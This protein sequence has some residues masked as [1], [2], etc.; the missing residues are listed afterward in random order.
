MDAFGI[1][2]DANETEEAR[3]AHLR[4]ETRDSLFLLAALCRAGQADVPV[5]VRNL[6]NGG[7]MVEG[8][9]LFLRGEAI[10][11]DLRGVGRVPGKV[12]WTASGRIGIAFDAPIDAK[13]ARKPVSGGPQ[14]Q[15]VKASR[16]MWR[17]GLR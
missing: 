17:P 16:T 3:F 10:E 8:N 1:S 4:A 7:M 5:K 12:A 9:G 14:P 6:S 15:L 2:D 11:A 13:L